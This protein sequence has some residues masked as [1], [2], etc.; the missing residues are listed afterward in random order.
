MCNVMGGKHKKMCQDLLQQEP[1]PLLS[2]F[3]VPLG[4]A[5]KLLRSNSAMPEIGYDGL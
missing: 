1:R 5:S 3:H 2:G 4:T